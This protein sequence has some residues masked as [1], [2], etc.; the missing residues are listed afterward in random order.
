MNKINAK[1]KKVTGSLI[2]KF[3]S[4]KKPYKIIIPSLMVAAILIAGIIFYVDYNKTPI[5]TLSNLNEPVLTINDSQFTIKGS[6][7]L[8]SD[9]EILIN[10]SKV[11]LDSDG[12]FSYKIDLSEGKNDIAITVTRNGKKITSQYIINYIPKEAGDSQSVNNPEQSNLN[13]DTNQKVTTTK[14]TTSNTV[15]DTHTPPPAQTPTPTPT[16]T[17]APDPTPAPIAFQVTNVIVTVSPTTL[18]S[19]NHDTYPF[20]FTGTIS[21]NAAG[22]VNYYWERTGNDAGG[23][24]V[25]GTLEFS[26]AESKSVTY[27]WNNYY[28]ADSYSKPHTAKL[29]AGSISS[30]ATY[31]RAF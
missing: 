9:S 24:A 3:K 31:S 8:K 15:T 11:K 6:I 28:P 21:A 14:E 29:V 1:F 4:L 12:S 7:D 23:G 17:P 5:L 27:T 10:E 19:G 20:V 26:S 2:R 22:T 16:P 18:A 13:T 30:Q 25:P